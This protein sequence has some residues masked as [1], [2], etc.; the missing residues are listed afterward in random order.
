MSNTM[1]DNRRTL[2]PTVAEHQ[3]AQAAGELA[4][5][6]IEQRGSR[7]AAAM[8][9]VQMARA[10]AGRTDSDLYTQSEADV[11]MAIM[12]LLDRVAGA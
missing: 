5:L 9:A 2:P 11:M 8:N 6:R 10:H 3:E 4:K 12:E 7:R 1:D